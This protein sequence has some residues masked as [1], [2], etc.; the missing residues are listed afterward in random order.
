MVD[1]FVW[2]CLVC[3]HHYII[4][5]ASGGL[6]PPDQGLCPWIPLGSGAN[7]CS[8]LGGGPFPLPIPHPL[9]LS[10][11]PFTPFSTPLPLPFGRGPGVISNIFLSLLHRRWVLAHFGRRYTSLLPRAPLWETSCEFV[12]TRRLTHQLISKR[13]MK[14]ESCMHH[15]FCRRSRRLLYGVDKQRHMFASYK[16]SSNYFII[17]PV[18]QGSL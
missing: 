18:K 17:P 10:P 12:V 1:S 5:S 4:S 8:I 6:L 15:G 2:E 7:C 13:I 9:S 14:L 3:A 16:C 11:A